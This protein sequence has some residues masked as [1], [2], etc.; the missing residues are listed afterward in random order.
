MDEYWNLAGDFLK[1]GERG[2]SLY[3]YRKIVLFR[4]GIFRATQRQTEEW[5]TSHIPKNKDINVCV[6]NFYYSLD[7]LTSNNIP[8]NQIKTV[9]V[10]NSEKMR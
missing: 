5:V 1:I 10:I 3:W 9:L 4:Y 2:W 8:G 7:L 6:D